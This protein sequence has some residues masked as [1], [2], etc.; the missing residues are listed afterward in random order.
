MGQ[1]AYLVDLGIGH[2]PGGE[3]D[4]HTAPQVDEAP[5]ADRWG[6]AWALIRRWAGG[7]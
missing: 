6:S 4:V 3:I 2:H 7:K 1:N 5:S